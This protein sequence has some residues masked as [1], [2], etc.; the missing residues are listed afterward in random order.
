MLATLRVRLLGGSAALDDWRQFAHP[1]NR[2]YHLLALSQ[3]V[4]GVLAG[5]DVVIP[6]ALEIGCP[7]AL[8][9]LLGALPIVGGFSQ[10]LVPGL[11]N[12]TE[13]NMRGLTLLAASLS[14]TRGFVYALLALAFGAGL[15]G[16]GLTVLLLAA[17][18]LLAGAAGTINGAN[19]L[20]WHSAVLPEEQ[21]RLIVP[22]LMALSLGLGALLLFP[23][24]LLLDGLAAH[25]GM[26]VYA[27]PF[28]VSG[29][30]GLAEVAVIRRLPHP[31]RMIVPPRALGGQVPES[32]DERQFLRVSMLNALGMGVT[33]YMAVYAMSVLGLSAGF[34][35]TVGAVSLL[36]MVFG[37]AVAG[38]ALRR[39]SSARMLR[40]SFALRAV[41]VALPIAALP[42]SAWAP[43]LLYASAA[44]AAIGFSSGQ[45]AANER[46]FRLI[47]GPAVIRQHG[48]YLARTSGAMAAGQLAAGGVLAAGGPLGY[49]VFALLYAASSGLRVLAHRA[50]SPERVLP[51]ARG[52]EPVIALLP[53][54]RPN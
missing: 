13:G 45:L 50:A 27:I 47:R 29:L 12:R 16:G 30:L 26:L 20:A 10:L 51:R 34:T 1:R 25:F 53:A 9:A 2:R 41:A 21:R 54:G 52:A 7:P 19:L 31:G 4:V 35:M 17:V 38:T 43:L 48:R 22:R 36:T 32:A 33:P 40:Q 24:A 37:A 8:A 39:G 6:F 5:F 44:L 18:I 28:A 15:L 11:L 3:G 42:G 46:L 23:M 14:E 49:P